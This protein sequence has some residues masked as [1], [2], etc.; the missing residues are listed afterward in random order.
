M[1]MRR[2][3]RPAA[4]RVD[5]LARDQGSIAQI[6]AD[7]AG[8]G[9]VTALFD[10]NVARLDDPCRRVAVE[11]TP[12]DDA[13]KATVGDYRVGRPDVRRPTDASEDIIA[14]ADAD[15][16]VPGDERTV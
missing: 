6:G 8:K 15:A 7:G 11:C 2:V 4:R 10:R 12:D 13:A 9:A 1:A 5:R 14:V 16:R 3:R